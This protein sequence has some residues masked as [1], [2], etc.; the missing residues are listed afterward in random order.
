M[1]KIG[2]ADYLAMLRRTFIKTGLAGTLTSSLSPFFRETGKTHI[3]TLSFDDG[4]KN[5]FLRIAAIFEDFD[6]RAC[7]N[8]IASGHLPEFQQ[9]D[10]W[11]RP[12]LMGDFDDWNNLAQR[13]HEIMPHSWKHLNLAR[14]PV[15]KAKD[16]IEKC[17][18]Y[19]ENNLDGYQN[20]TAVFNFPFNAST[21][22]LESYLL[23]R[24][25]GVRTWG[26]S[27]ISSIPVTSKSEVVGCSSRGPN[28]IDDWV[29]KQIEEFLSTD[30]GWLVLNL[31]GLEDEGWGPIS[32][33]FLIA[34]LQ[35]LTRIN[36]LTLLPTGKVLDVLE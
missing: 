35:K 24:V 31:H 30:G 26:K 12:E 33:N 13:G 23:E 5:S 18:E 4:F 17:L 1:D 16:L 22:E 7:L 32:T 8:V 19:F 9:V 21:P 10:H 28:N 34:L 15:E 3:L 14:Q 2:V 11:I 29:S 25:R 27:P 36:T 6:L 20:K